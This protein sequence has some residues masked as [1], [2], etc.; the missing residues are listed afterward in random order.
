MYYYKV[1]E[2]VYIFVFEISIGREMSK[3]KIEVRK[4]NSFFVYFTVSTQFLGG[5]LTVPFR[6]LKKT[7]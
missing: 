7:F 5:F 3:S 6:I 2:K 4:N 1:H